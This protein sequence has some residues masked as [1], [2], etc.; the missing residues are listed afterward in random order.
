MT[1]FKTPIGIVVGILAASLVLWAGFEAY[2]WYDDY[3]TLKYDTRTRSAEARGDSANVMRDSSALFTRRD[4]VVR[5]P[6]IVYRNSPQ[7]KRNPVADTLGGKSDSLIANLDSELRLKKGEADMLRRQV[8]DLVS[9]GEKP[10]PRAVP[11][12]EPLYSFSTTG[13]KPMIRAGVDYRILSGVNAKVEASYEAP[14]I[15]TNAP[16]F[17]L[18]VGARINFR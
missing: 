12:L 1:W 18:N 14:P 3:R 10:R 4:S 15:G 8:G 6:Y 13:G 2:G 11:Y 9:R 17:R 5:V 16:D 7:V